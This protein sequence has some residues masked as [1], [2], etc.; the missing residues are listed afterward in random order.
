MAV[1]SV[2][3]DTSSSS[4]PVNHQAVVTPEQYNIMKHNTGNNDS[5]T[6]V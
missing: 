2:E 4:G 3:P 6:K 1:L 5:K